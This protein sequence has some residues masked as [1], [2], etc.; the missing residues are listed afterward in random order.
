MIIL[1]ACEQHMAH[2]CIFN[3]LWDFDNPLKAMTAGGC[4]DIKCLNFGAP[5]LT[6]TKWQE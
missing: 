6:G 3:H 2:K 5:V 1:G 4:N